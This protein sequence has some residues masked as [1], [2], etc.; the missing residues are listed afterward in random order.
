M[1]C[2]Q[3]EPGESG[4]PGIVGEP[5]KKVNVNLRFTSYMSFKQ[6]SNCLN[7]IFNN[8]NEDNGRAQEENVVRK[9]K[10]DS[11]VRLVLQVERVPQEMMDLKE[12][13]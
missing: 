1:M 2:R 6:T 8:N 3:G 11:Q 9:V 12:T 7:L 5:G 13:L 4:P 10:L